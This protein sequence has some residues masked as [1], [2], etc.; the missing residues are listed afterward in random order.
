MDLKQA[1][2]KNKVG[3]KENRAYNYKT[4]QYE[5][6]VLTYEGT[7]EPIKDRSSYII[8]EEINVYP[9]TLC[10]ISDF[11]YAYNDPM[12][13][14]YFWH[15]AYDHYPL[16]GVSWKQAVAFNVWRTQLKNGFLRSLNR[17]IVNDYRLPSELEWEYA[18]RG[19]LSSS[20]YPWGGNYTRNYLGCFIAN[21][22][23]LRGNY[24]DDGGMHTVIVAHY[25][26]N[27]W[28][29]YDM[30][31]NVAEW[32]KSAFEESASAFTH[33][34]NTEN[35]Y[36]ALDED[37]IVLKR[38]VVRGG[39]WKDIAYYMQNGTRTYE[40]QDSAKSY[41]GFRSVQTYLG[42]SFIADGKQG[43]SQVY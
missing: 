11:T 3:G 27:E 42:R 5:G 23:P 37:P 12:A 30:A 20:P 32:T 6:E 28:G 40:Y 17:V 39:S 35:Y 15:P 38:K 22:K 43:E 36:Q 16:V 29:L 41:I 25:E 8:K 26:P 19:G 10:W 13:S 18:S 4:G 14:M 9:D 34:A 2:V 1:A 7:R 24:T 31:G 21:F 33:D